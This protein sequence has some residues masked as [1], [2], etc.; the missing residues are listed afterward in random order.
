MMKKLIVVL[1]MVGCM[2]L[3]TGCNCGDLITEKSTVTK[4]EITSTMEP[5]CEITFVEEIEVEE[6]KIQ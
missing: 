3:F 6:I 1:T 5:I 2:A 4:C